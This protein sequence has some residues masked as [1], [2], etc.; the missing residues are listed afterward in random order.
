M[1]NEVIEGFQL[2]P[3]QKHLWLLCGRHGAAIYCSQCVVRI[4][5]RLDKQILRQAIENVVQ[6]HEI[7]RTS[8]RTLPNM[9]MPVQVQSEF[10]GDD[11]GSRS[12]GD[13]LLAANQ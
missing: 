12:N 11:H 1:K 2:S 10:R 7:L 6:R 5:G 4:E 8:F 9:D 3:Q 13:R